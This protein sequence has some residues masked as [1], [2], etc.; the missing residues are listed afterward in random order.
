[1]LNLINLSEKFRNS[2]Q[3]KNC[4]KKKD[5]TEV[6]RGNYLIAFTHQ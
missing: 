6:K 5:K 4:L 3:K 2:L 1:M